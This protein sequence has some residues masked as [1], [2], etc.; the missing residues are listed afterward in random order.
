MGH[1]VDMYERLSF[2]IFIRLKIFRFHVA[3]Q[4]I[5]NIII[6]YA[7][8]WVL[9]CQLFLSQSIWKQTYTTTKKC[10]VKVWESKSV[11]TECIGHLNMLIWFDHA[12]ISIR[13]LISIHELKWSICLKHNWNFLHSLNLQNW[14]HRNR[15]LMCSC[16][17]FKILI[18]ILINQSISVSSQT[19]F[20]WNSQF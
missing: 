2:E 20:F 18:V 9:F 17:S 11:Q 15:T 14:N 4:N 19:R 12:I 16:F 6:F 10:I 1:L 7:H 8:F 13:I 3:H 5:Y